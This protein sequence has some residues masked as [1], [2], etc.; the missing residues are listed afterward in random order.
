MNCR[1]TGGHRETDPPPPH[2]LL[3][4]PP[5]LGEGEVTEVSELAPDGGIR[6]A[7]EGH[8]QSHH[9]LAVY[10]PQLHGPLQLCRGVALTVQE[11][12]ET[13]ILLV[14]AIAVRG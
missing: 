1:R 13:A 12:V 6:A 8:E 14:P 10:P 7:P 11:V 5:H 4:V 3:H 9:C 2:A